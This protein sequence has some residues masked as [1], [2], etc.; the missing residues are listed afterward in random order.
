MPL[1]PLQIDGSFYRFDANEAALNYPELLRAVAQ[2]LEE[3]PMLQPERVDFTVDEED[4]PIL[5]FEAKE[6]E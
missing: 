5:Y 3:N 4:D 6:E 1:E 2:F